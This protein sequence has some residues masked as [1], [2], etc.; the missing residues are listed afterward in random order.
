MARQALAVA[1]DNPEVLRN[2]AVA[3]A[4]LAAGENETALAALDRATE[5]N[6]NYAIA[7]AQRNYL[8]AWLNRPDEAI[9]AAERAV[10]LSRNDPVAFEP[11]HALCLAQLAAGR[12][13]EALLWA[14]RAVRANSGAPA[15]RVKLSLCGH[16]GR[17]EEA[18]KCLRLLRET[19]PEPTVAA[20]M[21]ESPKGLCPERAAR[22]AEGLRKAGLPEK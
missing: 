3:L 7:H 13:E 8:L 9:A 12:Y 11:P 10:R 14:D 22:M 1:S 5:L 21:S 16:L 15:L 19:H 2:A 18:E 6:P 17:L 20:M 4:G